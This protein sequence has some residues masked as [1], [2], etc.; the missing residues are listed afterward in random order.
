MSL[1]IQA[2]TEEIEATRAWV[3]DFYNGS[4]SSDINSWITQFYQSNAVLNFGNSPSLKG[5]EEIVSFFEKQRTILSSTKHD[6]LHVDVF[7]DRIYVQQKDTFIVKNDSEENEIEI[8]A[9][10]VIWKNVDE[11]NLSSMDVYLD[12][13]PLKERIKMFASK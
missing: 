9:V 1:P 4:N 13:T 3:R 11:N 12:P 2:T 8:K 10:V 7:S 6:I 5:H